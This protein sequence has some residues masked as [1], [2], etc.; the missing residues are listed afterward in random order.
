MAHL[1]A[2]GLRSV[3]LNFRGCSGEPNRL[4]R[5]Y[6]SGETGDL[7]FVIEQLRRRY[8]HDPLGV[9][10]FS[11]GG[12]VLLKY[13]GESS[14]AAPPIRAAA[15]ISVPFDLHA[16]VEA[17]RRGVAGRLYTWYFLRS[18]QRKL[19][20]KRD[21]LSETTL[22]G[23]L[24]AR[25]IEAFDDAVTAPMH[26]FRDA[27]DYYRRSSSSG[28]LADVNVP[29]LL[30]QATDDPFLP[31]AALPIDAI[32]ENP[33]FVVANPERGGHV[34]FL[35][36]KGS[37]GSSLATGMPVDA[38]RAH[39]PHPFLSRLWAEREAARFLAARLEG[40]GAG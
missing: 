36:G 31:R 25:D 39:L 10:G 11:L 16:C 7:D 6:H 2:R 22:R 20:A 4:P 17:L 37:H 9:V 34:G 27:R 38:G 8:P 1:R 3:A 23:G 15:T 33:A 21:L 12:N 28:F 40:T 32:R 14:D 24:A 18:L 13:L 5:A 29:T 35:E 30:L 26:G 19:E